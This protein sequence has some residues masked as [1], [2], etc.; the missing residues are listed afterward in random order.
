MR[1]SDPEG[2]GKTISDVMH[3]QDLSLKYRL[4]LTDRFSSKAEWTLSPP[5]ALLVCALGGM[6]IF[7]T[8]SNA[9]SIVIVDFP[10]HLREAFGK[11]NLLDKRAQ[12]HHEEGAK[13]EEGALIADHYSA[14][15]RPAVKGEVYL[16]RMPPVPRE[17]TGK[18]SLKHLWIVTLVSLPIAYQ[19]GLCTVSILGLTHSPFFFV[20]SMLDIFRRSDGQLVVS[21]VILA[22]PN[23]LRTFV[24]G[25]ITICCMGTYSYVY[26]STFV[27]ESTDFCHGF[28]QC[29]AVHFLD[30]LTGDISTVV[31]D[32]FGHFGWPGMTP[33]ADL[34][35]SYRSLF[36]FMSIVFWVFLL[37]GIIQGQIIDA[38]ATMRN[39]RNADSADLEN[40]CFVSSIERFVFNRYPGEWD[41][42]QAGRY[43]WKYLL[44]F[45]FLLDKDPEEYN[46]LENYVFLAFDREDVSFLPIMRF[47]ALQ[48][49]QLANKTHTFESSTK[50][51]AARVGR[52]EAGTRMVASVLDKV[53]VALQG[54]SS[55]SGRVPVGLQSMVKN[56]GV[57]GGGG[58]RGLMSVDGEV[59]TGQGRAFAR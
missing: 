40:K 51:L 31:G 11:A 5:V 30:S 54:P 7:F 17:Q 20:F 46:G 21:S 6:Q 33:S 27:N 16:A 47:I 37:Q 10:L 58:R 18:F 9:I 38:F 59:V 32:N 35:G 12:Q 13:S 55:G 39:K 44:Y 26:F 22:G 57:A 25:L 56:G 14:L 50:A 42:R 1:T 48:R 8:F 36:V 52:I 45:L 19:A 4:L 23:L 41:K 3:M 28:F 24:L 53:M 29:V 15:K 2:Y 49:E 43:A 34:W